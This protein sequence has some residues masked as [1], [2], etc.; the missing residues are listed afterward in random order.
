MPAG[1][2][3]CVRLIDI[4]FVNFPPLYASGRNPRMQE[5]HGRR[6]TRCRQ[7]DRINEPGDYHGAQPE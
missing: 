1:A 6:H 3:V 2:S 4:A 7:T 5:M